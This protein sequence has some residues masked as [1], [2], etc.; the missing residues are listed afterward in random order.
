M[1]ATKLKA[2]R[3]K[4]NLSQAALAAKIGVDQSTVHRWE[5]GTRKIGGPASRL[6]SQLV[7]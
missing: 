1:T 6:L 2:L 4:L 3:R 7:T 5:A